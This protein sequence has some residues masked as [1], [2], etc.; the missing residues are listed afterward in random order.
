MFIG[1]RIC[2][3][4]VEPGHDDIGFCVTSSVE[5]DILWYQLILYLLTIKI[6]YSFI[7]ILVYNDTK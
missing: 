6:Y 3:N 4:T 2:V 1:I 5:S 7:T